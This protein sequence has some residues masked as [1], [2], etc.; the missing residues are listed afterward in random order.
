MSR[1]PLSKGETFR[2]LER[3]LDR[4]EIDRHRL[5]SN[6]YFHALFCA[7]RDGLLKVPHRKGGPNRGTKWQGR[8]GF[9]LVWD[10]CV[11]RES[12]HRKS[13]KGLTIAEAIE[14]VKEQHP[15]K[16]GRYRTRKLEN[17]FYEARKT[18]GYG[19]LLMKAFHPEF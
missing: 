10:V 18:W 8:K 12:L 15:E 1:K 2:V 19:S 17:Y 5:D 3:L 14:K 6:W 4:Y 16:W 13:P 7:A 9:E 11:L